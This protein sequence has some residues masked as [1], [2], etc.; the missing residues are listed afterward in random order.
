MARGCCN[1][2]PRGLP[3]ASRT[4][5]LSSLHVRPYSRSPPFKCGSVWTQRWGLGLALSRVPLISGPGRPDIPNGA[6]RC[7]FDHSQ[8][9]GRVSGAVCWRRQ[10]PRWPLLAVVLR[11]GLKVR[12]AKKGSRGRRG[13]DAVGVSF[14]QGLAGRQGGGVAVGR[15]AMLGRKFPAVNLRCGR[16]HVRGRDM[17]VRHGPLAIARG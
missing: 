17:H 4:A 13:E 5:T 2:M 6:C 1:A 16:G 15:R 9:Q 3:I 8:P 11:R 10:S 14:M 12:R 7:L